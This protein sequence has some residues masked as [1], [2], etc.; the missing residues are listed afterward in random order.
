MEKSEMRDIYFE[1]ITS[2]V[3]NLCGEAAFNLPQDVYDAL[4]AAVVCE[5]S[6][7]AKSIIR[8]C[9]K[10]ADIAK[11]E[12]KPICQDTGF[13]VVFVEI[14]R[15]VRI[16][17][18]YD[19]EEAIQKGIRNGYEKYFLRKSIVEDPLFNRKNTN[20][21]CPAIIHYSFV[22]G[23]NIRIILAPK[24]GGS[25]NVSALKMLKPSDGEEGVIDF[26]VKTVVSAGGNPCPPVIVG[27]GIGGTAEKCLEI[28]KKALLRPIGQKHNI[29]FYCKIEEKI[30][31]EINKSGVGA[32]GLG[33]NIT[34]L[35]VHIETFATHIACLPIAVAINCHAARHCE[36]VL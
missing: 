13:A 15:F 32:Q 1:N 29:D 11:T 28:A 3:E 6:D 5:K 14:G 16:V 19:I 21:N 36:A 18:E 27:V 31:A 30:L 24:G 17:G 23:E 7:L 8:Q 35:A 25:E 22:E 2:A 34:A 20:D 33:G 9:V 4:T 26:V 12:E 10:N